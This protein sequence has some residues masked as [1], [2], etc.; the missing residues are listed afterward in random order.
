[1]NGGVA[2]SADDG[3]RAKRPDPCAQAPSRQ[4]W[5]L[6]EDPELAEGVPSSLLEAARRDLVVPVVGLGKGA[7]RPQADRRMVD[8]PLGVLVID[9]LVVRRVGHEGRYGAEVLG[10]GDVVATSR[11]QPGEEH[12]PG[13]L[14]S[15]TVV[16]AGR[17]A[18]LGP[19]VARRLG[20]YPE[21]TANLLRRAMARSHAL[22]A[23]LAVAHYPRVDRRLHEILWHMAQRWGR[24]T[25]EGIVLRLPLTHALLADLTAARRPSVTLAL[26]QLQGAGLLDRRPGEWILHGP[27]GAARA[28]ADRRRPVRATGVPASTAQS[29]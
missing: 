5:L 28:P 16:V 22:N 8:A 2:A 10:P 1:M 20:D 25:C 4:V 17:V 12:T 27:P 19:E 26:R 18:V 13:Y 29:G 24:V 9:G 15:M 6:R 7:W 11:A 23:M 14:T 3:S 21:V